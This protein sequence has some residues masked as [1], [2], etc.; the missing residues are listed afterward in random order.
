METKTLVIKV[1]GEAHGKLIQL[2]VGLGLS[3]TA[4]AR[5]IILKHLG[6]SVPLLDEV[7]Q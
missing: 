1:T 5:A 2:A 7:R 3:P 6:A 4:L